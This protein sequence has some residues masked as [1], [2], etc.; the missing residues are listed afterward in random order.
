VKVPVLAVRCIRYLPL[1]V[2]WTW[3]THVGAA[4]RRLSGFEPADALDARAKRGRATV[5]SSARV[6]TTGGCGWALPQPAASRMR[7]RQN[8]FLTPQETSGRLTAA[9]GARGG[10]PAGGATR[11]T[12]QVVVATQQC[13]EM[14]YLS[15]ELSE[16]VPVWGVAAVAPR[17]FA[18][19]V[20]R[21]GAGGSPSQGGVEAVLS[22][23][24]TEGG[25]SPS[26]PDERARLE[27]R[28]PVIVADHPAAVTRPPS[29]DQPGPPWWGEVA[30]DQQCGGRHRPVDGRTRRA[31]PGRHG[32]EGE[33]PSPGSPGRCAVRGC[34]GVPAG[35]PGPVACDVV[36]AVGE[37]RP[38]PPGQ[39]RHG[40][41]R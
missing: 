15:S 16:I 11:G 13:A 2:T 27:P 9:V 20:A 39:H 41:D 4:Y 18:A 14:S 25:A 31:D 17:S 32:N 30:V 6:E 3:R 10:K 7:F 38:Q 21:N 36:G 28:A 40:P 34:G 1:G 12:L 37:S 35:P 24:A 26:R 8:G 23:P 19:T 29:G 22:S 33:P 5:G